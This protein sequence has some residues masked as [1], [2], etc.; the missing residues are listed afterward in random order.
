MALRDLT[1]PFE[2]T[3]I[4]HTRSRRTPLHSIQ[5][6]YQL[7]IDLKIAVES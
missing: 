4:R 5:R 1:N 7:V 2:S 3:L 6:F